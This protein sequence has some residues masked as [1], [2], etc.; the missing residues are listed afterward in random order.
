MI[1]N[2]N[3]KY[4]FKITSKNYEQFTITNCYGTTLD[5][6]YP[7]EID[8]NKQDS[9]LLRYES[10][11]PGL[12]IGVKLNYNSTSDLNCNTKNNTMECIVNQSHFS[13][14]GDYYTYHEN[15]YGNYKLKSISY[16]IPTI[17]VIL[18]NSSDSEKES[19]SISKSALIGII[20]GSVVGVLLI[21]GLI[22]FFVYRH[23]RKSNKNEDIDDKIG[24]LC[25]NIELTEKVDK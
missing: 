8:F 13:K 15:Y 21:I 25:N 24:L 11:S 12:F 6:V 7:E 4:N 18:K 10:K 5:S 1:D 20:V 14:S 9:F 17:K 2:I 16:E 23:K 19:N 3:I 22:I